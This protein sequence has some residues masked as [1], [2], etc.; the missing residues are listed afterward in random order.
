M[1]SVRGVIEKFRLRFY[2]RVSGA[3]LNRG[4]LV[5][6]NLVDLDLVD[7]GLVELN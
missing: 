2:R 1:K 7:L 5:E 4:S 3:E 6:L